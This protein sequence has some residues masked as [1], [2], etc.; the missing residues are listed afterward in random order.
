MLHVGCLP[1]MLPTHMQAGLEVAPRPR[2]SALI[3]HLPWLGPAATAVSQLSMRLDRAVSAALHGAA[4]T[5]RQAHP[6]FARVLD[7]VYSL[8]ALAGLAH[9]TSP[10][11]APPGC[12]FC[13]PA[14]TAAAPVVQGAGAKHPA[15]HH[16]SAGQEQDQRLEL[17]SLWHPLLLASK[18]ATRGGQ[19]GAMQ[20]S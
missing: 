4:E 8:D 11:S 19:V 12:S 13:R 5:L 9:A 3:V 7:A 10:G 17:Q 15:H 6:C 14:F 16:A 18:A 2:S 1:V 20:Q